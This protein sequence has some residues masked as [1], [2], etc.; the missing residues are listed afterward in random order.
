[1]SIVIEEVGRGFTKDTVRRAYLVHNVADET[2]ARAALL[3]KLTADGILTIGGLVLQ[4]IA[5]DEEARNVFRC[6]VDWGPY[7]PAT[8]LQQGESSFAFEIAAQPIKVVV[9]LATTVFGPALEPSEVPQLIG[10]QRTIDPPE[11]C[12]IYEPV[13][14]FQE[15]H[16]I[17]ASTMTL[18]Y[19]N[20]LCRLIGKVNNATFKGWQAGEVLAMSVSGSRRASTDWEV[21]FR[22]S[23][24]ENKTGLTIAGISGIDKKGWEY[25]WPYYKVAVGGTSLLNEVTHVIVNQV[26]ATGNY[27]G[28]GIGV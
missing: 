15:T 4:N 19:R 1:M 20:A 24:R 11:G 3:A 16:I 2:T 26:F 9:P 7:Q 12:E 27:T 6:T 28:F 13:P 17:P 22:F 23:V 25:L 14:S 10:D 5:G 8:P 21:T 18:T